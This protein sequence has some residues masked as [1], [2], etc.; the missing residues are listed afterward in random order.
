ME[1]IK[2]ETREKILEILAKE[3]PEVDKTKLNKI[4]DKICSTSIYI[5]NKYFKRK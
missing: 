1:L 4:I 5:L 2:Q 3:N